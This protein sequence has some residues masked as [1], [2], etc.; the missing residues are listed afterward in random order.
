MFEIHEE[1]VL[2]E[3]MDVFVQRAKSLRELVALS[4]RYGDAE[5]LIFG[6]RRITFADHRRAVASV[7]AALR[8]RYGV[9][10]GDRVAIC[11]A[12]CPEW[13]VAFFAATSLGAIVVGM[14]GQWA[15]DEILYAIGDSEPSVLIGDAKRLARIAGAEVSVPVV[16]IES[17][18]EALWNHD[19]DAA[20]S[21]APIDEDDP[22]VILYTSGTTGRPKGA[23]NTHRNIIGLVQMMFFHGS[24]LAALRPPPNEPPAQHVRLTSSP[25]FHV[26]GLYAAAVA[27]LAG[28]VKSVWTTGRFDPGQVLTLIEREKVNGWGPQGSMAFRVLAYPDRANYDVSSVQSIGC[29][30]APITKKIQEALRETFPN[31]RLGLAVGYGLTEATALATMCY[32]QDLIDHPGSVGVPMPTVRVEIHDADGNA[33]P[34]DTEGEICIRSPLVMKEY[35]RKPKATAAA[36]G[37]G[38]WLRTGDVGRL[39]DGRLYIASRKR[40][41]ILRSAENIYPAEIEERLCAH[42]AV[43]EAAVI[44]VDHEE[45]GQEVKAIVVPAAGADPSV[46]ELRAHVAETLAAYKVPSVWEL[47]AKPLPRNASGKIVKFALR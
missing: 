11:A 5:F 31:A 43:S 35:W 26:S 20:I 19:L 34:D 9:K 14:N 4:E 15:G 33:L 27:H 1:E 39:V 44:G 25:L 42:P 18:F 17:S 12:N 36:I 16:D 38:R 47:R 29:G 37:P 22:A 6:D 13:I 24:R 7:A 28:G 30:G 32:G 41:M 23:V 46:D 45:L 21:D 40:D 2:G 3:R 10:H 8:D